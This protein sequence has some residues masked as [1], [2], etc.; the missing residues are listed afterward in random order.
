ET[1][2][3]FNEWLKNYIG[4]EDKIIYT[5]SNRNDYSEFAALCKAYK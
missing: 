5:K 1:L 4:V 3:N 2:L